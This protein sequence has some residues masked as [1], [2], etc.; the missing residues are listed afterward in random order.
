[1]KDVVFE[2]GGEPRALRFDAGTL[3]FLRALLNKDPLAED[4]GQDEDQAA[5]IVLAGIQ[6]EHARRKTICQISLLEVQEWMDDM[7]PTEQVPVLSA[8]RDAMGLQPSEDAPQ[9]EGDK[10]K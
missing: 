6:R 1:M 5:K 3:K 10:K 2:L 8:F 7:S 9:E 4:D